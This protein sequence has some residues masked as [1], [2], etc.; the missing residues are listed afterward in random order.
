MTDVSVIIRARDEAA[1]LGRCLE[2]IAEQ[3]L[4]HGNV[5]VIVVD[6]DSHDG[7]AEIARKAG[8]QVVHLDRD[9]F[10]FGRALNLGAAS[11]SGEL[12]VALS[13]HALPPDAGWLARLADA[14]SDSRVTRACGDLRG[15]A[16]RP[17]RVA[18]EQHLS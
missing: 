6:N 5:E 1:S 11:A 7:T 3:Q 18:G 10:T 13:A 14:L 9:A 8:A 2:L 15:P 17:P 12:L 16:G 4:A